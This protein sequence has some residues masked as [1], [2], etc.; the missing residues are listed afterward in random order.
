VKLRELF[1]QWG[2]KGMLAELDAQC[3]EEQAELI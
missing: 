3:P 2:F 1:R